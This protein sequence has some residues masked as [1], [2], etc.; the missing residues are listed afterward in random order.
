MKPAA[1]EVNAKQ[2][3]HV[4]TT[5][6][7]DT[8]WAYWRSFLTNSRKKGRAVT[9]RL[10]FRR[11]G[12]TVFYRVDDLTQF[13]TA[14]KARRAALSAESRAIPGKA[15]G[16]TKAFHW[17]VDAR[18]EAAGPTVRLKVSGITITLSMTPNQA[19]DLAAELVRYANRF[20]T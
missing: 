6:V 3:A 14:E 20:S 13:A 4:L 9:R 2:A 16:A 18:P 12:R 19:R 11:V 1:G 17:A 15:V 5:K 8:D 10:P 7:P